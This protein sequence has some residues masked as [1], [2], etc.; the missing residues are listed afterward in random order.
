MAVG[1]EMIVG[2]GVNWGAHG[3]ETRPDVTMQSQE[4]SPNPF[5]HVM[6]KYIM[7]N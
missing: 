1:L 7:Q 3:L 5:R 6:T 2:N 4:T